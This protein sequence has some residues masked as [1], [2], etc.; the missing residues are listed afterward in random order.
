MSLR[1]NLV[2]LRSDTV[3]RPTAEMYA[4]MATA[5]VGD[6]GWRDDPTVLELE[7]FCAA[8]LGKPAALFL[9]SGTMSNL[10]AIMAHASKRG[11]LI[12]ESSSHIISGA[13]GGY[14]TVTGLAARPISG[15]RGAMDLELLEAAINPMGDYT[16]VPTVMISIENTHTAENGAVLP[17]EHMAAVKQLATR[18]EVPL[19]LDG[20]RL[21]NAAIILG[22]S[23]AELAV[24]SDT[25]SICL[26]KGIGAPAGAILA[27]SRAFIDRAIMFRRMLGGAMRQTGLLAACALVALESPLERLRHHHVRAKELATGLHRIDNR[28]LDLESVVTNLITLNVRHTGMDAKAWMAALASRG[29]LVGPR[30][31]GRLRLVTHSETG[32]AEIEAA[33]EAFAAIRQDCPV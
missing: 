4:A 14:A 15:H 20:A 12:A 2:D 21:F 26:C 28:L 18:S 1:P 31:S 13:Q 3:T 11:E 30:G 29:V 5:P 32:P 6:D 23:L 25:V 17:I 27:G 16:T 7:S 10:V 22:V 9:P 24:H 19:H 8:M 33:L